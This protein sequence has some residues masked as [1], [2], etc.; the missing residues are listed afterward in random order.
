MAAGWEGAQRK[1][2]LDCAAGHWP[3]KW[4]ASTGTAAPHLPKDLYTSLN[5]IRTSSSGGGTGLAPLADAAVAAPPAAAAACC[6]G[7]ALQGT[8]RRPLLLLLLLLPPLL[9][10]G[11]GAAGTRRRGCSGTGGG[12][13]GA[14]RP[15]V[16]AAAS[17]G[18]CSAAMSM[19]A[20]CRLPWSR[21][22]AAR[23][24]CERACVEA[25]AGGP[26]SAHGCVDV[27]LET[28]WMGLSGPTGCRW[29]A[30][31]ASRVQLHSGEG[32][33]R[34]LAR[35]CCMHPR[36]WRGLGEL[37]AYCCARPA[38]LPPP[39]SEVQADRLAPLSPALYSRPLSV[40]GAAPLPATHA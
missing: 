6:S 33:S 17:A 27:R 23:S 11:R 12:S 10:L 18:R 24:G 31:R 19:W 8:P 9:L 25:R 16:P 36:N 35:H 2:A 1:H 20:A 29:R 34:S 7:S 30:S 39:P 40:G 22:A 5:S 4:P 37:S 13:G 3:P 28:A 14:A 26:V 32:R 38:G 15:L 21:G